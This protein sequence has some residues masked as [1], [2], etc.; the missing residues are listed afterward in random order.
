[1]LVDAKVL[2]KIVSAA[3]I[4]NTEVVCEA[5][6]GRG[7]LTAELCKRARRVVSF[8][9]DRGLLHAAGKELRCENLDLI[10]GDLFS[11]HDLD[12]DVFVSNLPYSRSR[13]AFEW[14]ASQKFDRAVVMVQR[15]F[16]EK[17]LASPGDANYRAV[18]ALANYCFSIKQIGVVGKRSFSPQ[19]SVE[20]VILQIQPVNRIKIKTIKKLNWLFSKRNRK[21][22][23]VASKMGISGFESEARRID[24][25]PPSM[26]I[27][28]ADKVNDIRP[29]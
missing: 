22:S 14:L 6:T 9:V 8:E 2:S 11:R 4:S 28:M 29:I 7:V 23:S 1:M 21:A 15:E 3:S 20:S 13:D 10:E 12:F 18:S 16:A 27:E 5:G 17:V 25:L 19:P 26:L 24:G